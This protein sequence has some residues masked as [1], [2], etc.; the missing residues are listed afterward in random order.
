MLPRPRVRSGTSYV[1]H[2]LRERARATA[3]YQRP[4]PGDFFC[5]PVSMQMRVPLPTRSIDTDVLPGTELLGT[6]HSVVR[7]ATQAT[8]CGAER[9]RAGIY[10]MVIVDIAVTREKSSSSCMAVTNHRMPPDP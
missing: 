7:G 3:K 9:P 6:C 1:R 8:A 4:G 5:W 2:M 10:G